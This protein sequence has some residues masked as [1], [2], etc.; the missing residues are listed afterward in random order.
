MI[1]IYLALALIVHLLL[2]HTM[3]GR[4]VYAMGGDKEAARRAGFDVRRVTY[5][6]YCL[7]GALAGFAGLL[8]VSMSWLANPRDLA[9]T[10][11]DGWPPSCSAGPA[12]S[13]AAAACSAPCSASSPWCW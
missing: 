4:G 8:Y 12:S 3:I 5:F 10:E 1:V 6:V 2:R 9:G 7:S 13:A 11:I